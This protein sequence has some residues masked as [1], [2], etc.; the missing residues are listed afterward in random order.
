[1]LPSAL[2]RGTRRLVAVGFARE[3]AELALRACGAAGGASPYG[4]RD[5]LGTAVMLRWLGLGLGLGLALRVRV[6]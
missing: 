6:L 4:T 1:M 5:A 3:E 2:A